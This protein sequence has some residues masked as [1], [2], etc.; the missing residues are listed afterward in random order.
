[1]KI[2]VIQ[3]NS[4]HDKAKNL[5]EAARLA[6]A[7]IADDRPDMIAFPEMWPCLSG[8]TEIKRAAAENLDAPRDGGAYALLQGLAR[9]HG[10]FVHGGSI[11]EA[12]GNRV[13]NT[14]VA[15]G[16]DGAERARYR[17]IHLF[18]VVTPDG[19]EYRESA[20]MGR[21]DA[22]VTYRAENVTVGCA[23]CYDLRFPELF[24]ALEKAGADVIMLP[25]AF[26]LQTGKDHWETLCRARAI[27]TQT[28]FVAPAQ[29]GAHE[30][31][32]KPRQCYGH[33]LVAD[34]WGHVV[35]RARDGVGHV[36]ARIDQ[37]Y[38]R[39][40][41]ENMPTREHHVMQD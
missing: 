30:E 32:G 3:M 31:N 18:D 39:Q 9:A 34:P 16:R 23:I 38:L 8:G 22:V 28:Y 2:S 35:A 33:S 1:M 5:A 12:G 36:T 20:T 14:T 4:G 37:D 15:F 21:G 24:R 10:I 40:V 41:R 11:P 26:T 13:Y 27:E 19:R 6:R 17:K 25:S 7:A 29:W